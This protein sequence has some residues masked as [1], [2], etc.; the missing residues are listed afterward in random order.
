MV[1]SERWLP[2]AQLPN[3]PPH[4]PAIHTS[5]RAHAHTHHYHTHTHTN[6]PTCPP[7]AGL[8]QQMRE[9]P[10]AVADLLAVILAQPGPCAVQEQQPAVRVVLEYSPYCHLA[11]ALK[12]GR[13]GQ[14]GGWAWQDWGCGGAMGWNDRR[15]AVRL[16]GGM[17]YR[18]M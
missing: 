1:C 11:A 10:A 4:H 9:G 16:V 8:Q 3:T 2:V 6:N 13:P 5:M 14:A 18:A 7:A 12:W 15:L 17:W